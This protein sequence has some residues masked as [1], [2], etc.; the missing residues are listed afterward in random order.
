MFLFA[1]AFQAASRDLA[2]CVSGQGQAHCD[3][4]RDCT[5]CMQAANPSLGECY[6]YEQAAKMAKLKPGFM[7]CDAAA[8]ASVEAIDTADG[9]SDANGISDAH[10]FERWA[11]A[12]DKEYMADPAAAAEKA[13]RRTIF[14]RHAARIRASRARSSGYTQGLAWNGLDQARAGACCYVTILRIPRRYYYY[15]H[16]VR[17]QQRRRR[18]DNDDD[19][20][21]TTTARIT[22]AM[23]TRMTV[24]ASPTDRRGT[25][26]SAGLPR[27][28]DA[29][30][31]RLPHAIGRHATPRAAC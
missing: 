27:A 6:S 26:T 9:P 28:R 15:T 19:D 11:T 7:A 22:I 12:H 29:A 25:R 23:V 17:R 14:L 21:T 18:H 16:L 30:A 20:T 13:H 4:Q 3:A 5:W 2:R 1:V 31:T 24:T 8:A 10:A